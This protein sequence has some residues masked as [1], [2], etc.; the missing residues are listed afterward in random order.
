MSK[1]MV[2]TLLIALLVLAFK[3]VLDYKKLLDS[4][5]L[6]NGEKASLKKMFNEIALLVNLTAITA[7]LIGSM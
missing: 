7:Y 3:F 4:D 1:I 5:K 2:V 6:D